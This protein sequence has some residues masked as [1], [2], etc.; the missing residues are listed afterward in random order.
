MSE[1]ERGF[2][3][4]LEAAVD[5]IDKYWVKQVANPCC[6][7]HMERIEEIPVPRAPPQPPKS[8]TP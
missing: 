8:E 2:R 6:L 4:G 7:E 5:M 1:Y 3:A